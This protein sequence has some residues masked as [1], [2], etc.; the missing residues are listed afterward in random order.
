VSLGG[1]AFPPKCAEAAESRQKKWQADLSAES[2]Q[3]I[4]SR[5]YLP[6]TFRILF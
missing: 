4:P 6:K 5:N 1:K 2:F 3:I